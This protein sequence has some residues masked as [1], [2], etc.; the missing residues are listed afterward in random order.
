[1]VS[2]WEHFGKHIE[3]VGNAVKILCE[4]KWFTTLFAAL[5]GKFLGT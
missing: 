1:M 2:S 4:H 3:H 5:S